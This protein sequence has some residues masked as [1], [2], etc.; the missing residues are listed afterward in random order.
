MD[1]ARRNLHFSGNLRELARAT[2][3]CGERVREWLKA[4]GSTPTVPPQ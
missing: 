3:Q 4:I 1:G 2:G